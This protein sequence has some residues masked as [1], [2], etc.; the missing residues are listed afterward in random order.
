MGGLIARLLILHHPRRGEKVVAHRFIGKR[1][2]NTAPDPDVESE[3]S[4]TA[5]QE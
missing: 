2:E 1:S 4:D 5:D 3:N